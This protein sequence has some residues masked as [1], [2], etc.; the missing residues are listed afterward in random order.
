LPI[1]HVT[2]KHYMAAASNNSNC[3]FHGASCNNIQSHVEPQVSLPSLQY[4]V[5]G[6]YPE[7]YESN[8]RTPYLE[9]EDLLPINTKISIFW[10]E[11]VESQRLF[12]RNNATKSRL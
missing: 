12:R 2:W 10:N 1:N 4:S 7:S 6:H 5:T 8:L 11:S 9:Y 3:H